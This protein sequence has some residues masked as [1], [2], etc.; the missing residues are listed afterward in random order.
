MISSLVASLQEGQ[1]NLQIPPALQVM[2]AF[3]IVTVRK[4]DS[5]S[6]SVTLTEVIMATTGFN[7]KQPP[8][9]LLYNSL[10]YL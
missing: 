1:D 9:Y 8:I 4:I 5:P 2:G 3:H 7:A 6:F 10:I